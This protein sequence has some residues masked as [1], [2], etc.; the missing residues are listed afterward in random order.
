M[1]IK[2]RFKNKTFLLALLGSI[3][4]LLQQLGINIFPNNI[5]D[6]VNTIL[7]ILTM[8]GITVDPS[9]PGM[10]DK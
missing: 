9:S 6:I 5:S 10:F 2:A 4:L 7:V 3:L 8:V 1:K